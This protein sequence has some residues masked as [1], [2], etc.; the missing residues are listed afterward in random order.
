LGVFQCIG[1]AC[2]IVDEKVG[3]GDVKL[4][5]HMNTYRGVTEVPR[6]GG[7]ADDLN[8]AR[9][10]LVRLISAERRSNQLR[11]LAHCIGFST[12]INSYGEN[13][14]ISPFTECLRLHVISNKLVKERIEIDPHERGSEEARWWGLLRPDSTSVIVRDARSNAL[15]LLTAGDPQVVTTLCHE[16]WQGENSTILPLASADRAT[17]LETSRSW[18][19]ADLDVMAFSYCPVPHTVE[20]RL[21]AYYSKKVMS[22]TR[23]SAETG[24]RWSYL[25]SCSVLFESATFSTIRAERTK[26]LYL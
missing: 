2:L 14:D 13:G 17:I 16:A 21:G 19:L 25:M 4:V 26:G 20:K 12:E 22:E 11:S 5:H 18:K 10:A 7:T 6:G 23:G 3:E 8:E 9:E 15:Q 1:L 24:L